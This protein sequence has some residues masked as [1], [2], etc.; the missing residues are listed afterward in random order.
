[1]S[2]NIEYQILEKNI[3]PIIN[4]DFLKNYL[5]VSHDYDD[6]LIK[7]QLASAVE[8]TEKFLELQINQMVVRVDIPVMQKN[9]TLPHK[10]ITEIKYAML[11]EGDNKTDLSDQL[12][13]QYEQGVISPKSVDILDKKIEVIY[14]AGFVNKMPPIVYNGLLHLVRRLYESEPNELLDPKILHDIFY[15]YRRVKI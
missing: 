8:M 3:E 6:D 9:I 10:P 11:I 12:T 15:S 14:L 5:R 2:R 7:L 13:I 4:I 1:M